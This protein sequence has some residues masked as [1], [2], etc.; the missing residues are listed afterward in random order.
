[1]K[2]S[3][4]EASPTLHL[5]LIQAPKEPGK[6]EQQQGSKTGKAAEALVKLLTAT[7]FTPQGL[8]FNIYK[9]GTTFVFKD[10][11]PTFTKHLHSTHFLI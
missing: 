9:L 10:E 1:M 5:Y 2:E 4:S 6:A 8:S 7:D 11:K 3:P